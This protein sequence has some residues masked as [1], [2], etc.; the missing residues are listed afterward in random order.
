VA[1]EIGALRAV[2]ALESAA[3]A[4]GVQ[5]ARR[6]LDGF[7][8]RLGRTG[9]Q[10]ETV[11]RTI[12]RQSGSFFRLAAASRAGGT[13]LAN[14]GFQ[15]QDFAVQVGAGTSASQALAQQLPQLLSGFGLLGIA[16]GT[17]A[18]VAIPLASA[19]FGVGT[20]AA[21]MKDALRDANAVLDETSGLLKIARGDFDS[22]R[23]RFG[24]LTPQVLAFVEAQKQI[25]LRELG[26][27]AAGLN[28][29]LTALYN[30]SAW[31]N[32]SRAEDLANGLNLGTKA[33]RELA[34][35]LSSL[36]Q[37]QTLDGQLAIVT[38]LRERFV[39][40]VGPVGQMTA[41]QFQFYSAVADSEAKMRELQERVQIVEGSVSRLPSPLQVALTVTS[42]LADV[43][44]GL[45]GTFA[46]AEGVASGL[47][48][49]L[50]RAAQNAWAMASGRAAT[51]EAVG[52][53]RGL[54]PGGP[55]L[56][57]YGFRSQIGAFNRAAPSSGGGGRGTSAAQKEANE[58]QRE[59]ARIIAETRTESEK[60]AAQV[61]KLDTLLASGAITQDTYN[62]AI[63]DLKGSLSTA[64]DYAG[65]LESSFESAF[66]SFVTGASTAREAA[67]Q[68]L[69]E[70]A[71]LFA[72]SAFRGLFAGSNFFSNLGGFLA[73]ADGNAFSGGR[74]Q[75]FANGGI[76]NGP[77]LFPM[78]NGTGLM[79]EAGPEAVMPLTRVGGKLGVR[80][81]GGGGGVTISIDARGAVEG[82]AELIERKIRDA[83]PEITRRG[84]ATSIA[85]GKRGYA[86]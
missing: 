1:E 8:S 85:A 84:V 39:E 59:A 48:D 30:G 40:I 36:S 3:F 82:T 25:G 53:G 54:G 13:G 33:S 27:A 69:G 55:S 80:A 57:P 46:A 19:L 58:L 20:S 66:T 47:A 50:G 21:T 16:L 12:D 67:S 28:A 79:G 65:A 42:Q 71:Q 78:A 35:A 64:A 7:E 73:N 70:L 4:A 17:A 44:A 14:V 11:G 24:E 61:Q 41:A 86:A 68:L 37:E 15:L 23:E 56:D 43:A 32:V 52:G 74:V 31:L 5:K 49:T 45:A 81:V 18:A 63:E 34:N 29:Q 72:Q 75:A 38:Q 10:V 83:I 6:E 77:T 76:V 2:L 51:G 22:V 62:R 9:S 26:E 60:Y